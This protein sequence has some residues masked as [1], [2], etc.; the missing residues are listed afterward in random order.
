MVESL[1]SVVVSAKGARFHLD[2]NCA[3]YRQGVANSAQLG[4]NLHGAE[5]V[6]E[7]EARRRGKLPCKRCIRDT[8]A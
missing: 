6:P 5:L 8:P 2:E 7:Q 4:R 3:G 1:K